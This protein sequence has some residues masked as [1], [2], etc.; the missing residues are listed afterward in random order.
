MHWANPFAVALAVVLSILGYVLPIAVL[1]GVYWL[2]SMPLRRRERA[3]LFLDLIE[4][5]LEDGH[6]PERTIVDVAR[7][8]DTMLGARFHLLAAHI[9]DGLRLP[10][11]L[12]KVRRLLPP[13]ITGM[14]KVGAEIGD[15]RHVLPACRHAL[16]DALSQTRGAINYLAI[17]VFVLLPAVP[18]LT[19]IMSVFILPKF[20]AIA[21]DMTDNNVPATMRLVFGLQSPVILLQ[22]AVMLALQFLVVCYVAGPR[23]RQVLRRIPLLG[24]CVD[25][26]MWMMPWRRKRMQ[27]DFASMLALLLDA[28]VPEG[29][30]VTIASE[31]TSNSLFIG[32]ARRV[33]A[34]LAR[35]VALPQALRK[36]DD[37]HEFAWRL[38]NAAHGSSGFVAALRGWFEALDAKAFQQEQTAAQTLTT[39]VVLWNGLMIGAFVI[40][41]F[42]FFAELIHQAALW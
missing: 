34:E 26:L 42:H 29:R 3:R 31:A 11:A 7:N 25:R 13:E 33:T 14:L 15:I 39:G 28:G 32:R 21:R 24:G 20:E 1:Y 9:E 41:V 35:G 22:L 10:E 27:R 30:A 38:A 5:G 40:A 12:A 8:K 2:V 23:L 19:F 6:T 4:T 16:N 18:V 36:L 37:H 17:T